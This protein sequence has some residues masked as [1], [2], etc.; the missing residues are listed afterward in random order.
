MI[1]LFVFLRYEKDWSA[2]QSCLER[3]ESIT[4][5]DSQFLPVDKL[6]LDG[7]LL[8]LKVI[9]ELKRETTLIMYFTCIM[10]IMTDRLGFIHWNLNKL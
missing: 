2:L 5:P 6:K 7:E 8:E 10:E 4:S 3:C 1:H 9:N